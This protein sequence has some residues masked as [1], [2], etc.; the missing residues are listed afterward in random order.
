MRAACGPLVMRTVHAFRRGSGLWAALVLL[1]AC[2]SRPDST[3]R[4]IPATSNRLG[5]YLLLD[6]GRN[7]WPVEVWPE[8][9]R[10]AHQAVGEWGYVTQLVRLDDLDPDRWQI[11]MDLCAELHLTPVLRLA[12]VYDREADRWIAPP[13]DPNGTYHTVATRYADFA[14]AL[15][16]PTGEHFV[17]VGNEP[18]HG[19][20]W[21]G[22]PDPAA[23]ARFLI[24]VT[25]A[26]HAADPGARVLNAGFDAYAPHTGGLPFVDGGVYMDEE[27]F[28]DG[29]VAAHPDVFTHIDAWASHAYPQ[30]PFA[31]GPWRQSYQV[32]LLNGA[33]NPAH[34]EPPEGVFNRG[35]NGYEWELYKLATYGVGPLP[36][37][38]TETG[39]RHAESADPAS[40]DG[41][42][43]LPDAETMAHYLDLALH[44]NE[45]RYPQY[46]ETGWTPWLDDPRVVAVTLF[47]LDGLPS[48]WGHTNLLVLDA[49]GQVLGV[50]PPF[51]L[52]AAR[53]LL[54]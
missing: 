2:A 40:P 26:L 24:D 49:Q 34:I 44:G 32:D 17:V 13:P 15:D 16:W 18:N 42:P 25:N 11:F 28:L 8:H 53:S 21:G 46:P 33:A 31:E 6:D 22:Q 3:P 51:D 9:L 19:N 35:V 5:V 37:L 29:M 23:Y 45:G 36:V 14:A 43:A 27:S 7:H 1:A 4:P 20:E 39:W 47:A 50:Y 52:L 38:I 12:T 41:G 30:G 54:P 10:H 48:E